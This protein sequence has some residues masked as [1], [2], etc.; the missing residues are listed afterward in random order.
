MVTLVYGPNAYAARQ[1]VDAIVAKYDA[2]AIDRRDG[3][4]I[5]PD[6]LPELLQGVSLFAAERVVVLKNAAQNKTLWEAIGEYFERIPDEI[7][8]VLVETAPDKRTKT[9]KALQK[10]AELV[11]CEELNEAQ[12]AS[13]LVEEAKK[14][15]GRIE[16]KDA[17]VLVE[18]IG[19]DQW[20][21]SHA[22]EK[23][24]LI[25]D[26][27]AERIRNTVEAT[28]QANVFALLDAAFQG[29]VAQVRELLQGCIAQEDPY[30]FFGL[31]GSQI[32][33]LVA[34]ASAD[35]KTPEQ[36]AK[37]IGAHPYP[38]KKLQQ[39]ARK[40][41]KRELGGVVEVVAKLD[42]QMKSSAGEP[43]LLIETALLRIAHR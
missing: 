27:S 26:T 7:H 10:K 17:M 40:L 8:V 31:L 16:R 32:F 2:S 5:T 13:W 33:Q 37:D 1:A 43:W 21:L 41:S 15:E 23:L 18:R 14:R 3:A 25:G 22:L 9:Y 29:R 39:L 24:L 36:I 34:V 42:D 19:T 20:Q 38:L 30:K 11:S 6:D 4:D 12:A 35:G 28:P